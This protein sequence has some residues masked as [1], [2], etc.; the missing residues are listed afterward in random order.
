M[1]KLATLSYISILDAKLNI[2]SLCPKQSL[3]YL[4]VMVSAKQFNNL[5]LVKLATRLGFKP[6]VQN[7][8]L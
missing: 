1:L 4:L 3:K 2:R 6:K 7:S 8:K 5:Q